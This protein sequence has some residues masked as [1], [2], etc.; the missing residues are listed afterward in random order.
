[1]NKQKATA[2]VN[3][4]IKAHD[5]YLDAVHTFNGV[6]GSGVCSSSYIQLGGHY[7]GTRP[8]AELLGCKIVERPFDDEYRKL[9]IVHQGKTFMWLEEK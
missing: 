2:A 5:L 4:L 1:M 7:A 3:E 6:T 9:E 8:L